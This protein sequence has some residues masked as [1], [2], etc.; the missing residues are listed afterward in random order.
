ADVRHQ[1]LGIALANRADAVLR[2]ATFDEHAFQCNGT[3]L[4]DN[5]ILCAFFIVGGVHLD[6]HL[7]VLALRELWD[8]VGDRLQ[9]RRQCLV[10][11]AHE[12]LAAP[13]CERLATR[14]RRRWRPHKLP[15][16]AFAKIARRCDN[17]NAITVSFAA[18]ER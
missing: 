5:K 18:L 10:T 15:P 3:T 2:N 7:W 1:R 11:F 16:A 8:E 13:Q 6:G 12:K 17:R 4:A 14:R 9:E